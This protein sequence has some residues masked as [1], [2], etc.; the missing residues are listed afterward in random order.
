MD[1]AHILL[2]LIIFILYL[3]LFMNVSLRQLRAFATLAD[4]RSFAEASDVLHLS[5]PALSVAIKNMEQAV[6]GSL[7][8]RSTRSVQL[9]PEGRQFLPVARRLLADWDNAFDDLGRAFNLQQGKVS[10]A[11]MPSFAV[12]QL[13]EALATFQ[14]ACPDI[15]ITVEDIVMELVIDAVRQGKVDLGVTFEPEQ[16]DGVDFMPL[17]TDRWIALLHAE[18]PLRDRQ[19]LSW[20]DLVKEPFIAMNRGSWSRSTTDKAMADAG[21]TPARLLE[22]NQIATIGRM[23]S[24][25]LG[26]AVVPALCQGQMERLGVVCRAFSGPAITRRVGIFTRRRHPLSRAASAMI[27]HLQAHFGS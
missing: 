27:D 13:P 14:S 25:G 4:S 5:Q 10:V 20:K 17:F 19:R 16:L 24:V 21:V 1:R 18:S 6:G 23:V 9:S 12:N 8:D 15:N 26:T 3:L 22:A 2:K 11:V 7:F